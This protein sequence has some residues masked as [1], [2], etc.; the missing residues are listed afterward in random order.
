LID[1][2]VALEKVTAKIEKAA[3]EVKIP[4]SV[5]KHLKEKN[6]KAV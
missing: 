3:G 4:A 6:D 5:Y 2:E 1:N